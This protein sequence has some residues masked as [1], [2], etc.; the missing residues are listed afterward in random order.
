MIRVNS[1]RIPLL[2]SDWSDDKREREQWR[3]CVKSVGPYL[4][5]MS[6]VGVNRTGWKPIESSFRCL[7]NCSG[8]HDG[9]LK[10][11]YRLGEGDGAIALHVC[12]LAECS[13]S[14]YPPPARL[15][16]GVIFHTF[17][18]LSTICTGCLFSLSLSLSPVS[19][20]WFLSVCGFYVLISHRKK[21][22][23]LGFYALIYLVK[24]RRCQF[25]CLRA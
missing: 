20:L 25:N 14:L 23:T 9:E 11:D 22:S 3:R 13:E 8:C 24:D 12:F 15:V 2:W 5:A 7:L 17:F 4:M 21:P 1:R 18:F 19:F 16:P 10:R 6:L